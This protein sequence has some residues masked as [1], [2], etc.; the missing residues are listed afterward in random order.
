ML[1]SCFNFSN[2]GN[3]DNCLNMKNISKNVHCNNNNK[4]TVQKYF[5]ARH[6][7]YANIAQIVTGMAKIIIYNEEFSFCKTKS[8]SANIDYIRNK[9]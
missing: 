9:T 5:N 3:V 2:A 8:L 4:K 6:V 1:K 7:E